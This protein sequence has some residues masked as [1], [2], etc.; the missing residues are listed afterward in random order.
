[1]SI[2]RF[3]KKVRIEPSVGKFF[4]I[5]SN[6]SRSFVGNIWAFAPLSLIPSIK[7]RWLNLS[8]YRD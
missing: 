7:L 6:L 1:M 2:E 4:N 3:K 5:F 8:I